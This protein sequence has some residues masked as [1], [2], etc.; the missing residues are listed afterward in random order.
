MFVDELHIYARA[1][2]GGDGVVRFRHLKGKEKGGPS[3]GNG[4]RGGDVYMRAVRDLNKLYQYRN[5]KEFLAPDGE[6]G[7]KNSLEGSNG[8]G[9]VIDV[10]VGSVV[11]KEGSDER[12]E[13]LEEGQEVV[14]LR[15][16]KGGL[17]NEHFKSSTN[18]APREATS[19]KPG[20]GAEF[21]I[22]VEL[23][24]D[25]GFIGFPNAGKSSLLNA[26]TRA[27][28]KVADYPFTTL[29]PGLGEMY[30]YVLA[31]IPGL[32]AG[33]AEGKGLGH[34]FLRHV[35]RTKML[36]H[37]ISLENEDVVEV[38]DTIRNELDKFDE[39]L[40]EKPEMIILTKTDLLSDDE[41]KAARESLSTKGERV[42][43]VSIY[44]DEAVKQLQDDMIH[45]LREQENSGNLEH[46][47]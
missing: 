35:K 13:L 8:E 45:F 31:D 39:T 36:L 7:K 37:C 26:L 10:P 34:K 29:E 32:I 5:K 46:D 16:G 19:G 14:V 17:G 38:Y 41:V 18:Q 27:K 47:E 25:A 21:D 24:V 6:D 4:G 15:G 43:T 42:Y 9:L 30:G 3:G 20:E 1:G 11:T 33:A 44:D 22:E 12:W 40:K 23:I 28:R 2:K